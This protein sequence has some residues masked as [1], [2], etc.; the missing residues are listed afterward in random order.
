MNPVGQTI[1]SVLSLYVLV[2]I[3][4]IVVDYVMIFARDWRPRGVVLVIVEAIFTITDPPLRV[5]R[6]FV[7]PLRIGGVSLDLA[8]LVLFILVLVLIQAALRLPI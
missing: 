4:R 1:A 2:L 3:A 6:R 8:F 5:L 7:P